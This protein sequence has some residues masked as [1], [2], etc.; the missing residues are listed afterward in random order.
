MA[1]A[2]TKLY[3]P[4][5]LFG[6]NGATFSRLESAIKI[7]KHALE[8]TLLEHPNLF[9]EVAQSLS[10]AIS[11]RDELKL[12]IKKLEA[13]LDADI[14]LELEGDGK[15]VTENAVQRAIQSDSKF[16]KLQYDLLDANSAVGRWEALKETYIQRSYATKDLV[17]LYLAHYYSETEGTTTDMRSARVEHARKLHARHGPNVSDRRGKGKDRQGKG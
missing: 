4:P 7:D 6:V 8:D 16:D 17:A 10:Y 5:E 9:G 15:K 2:P 14:R 1:S 13:D 3:K 12:R 11:V